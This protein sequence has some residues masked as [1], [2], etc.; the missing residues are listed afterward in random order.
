MEP[1]K[2]QALSGYRLVSDPVTLDSQLFRVSN[3]LLSLS[4]LRALLP[5]TNPLSKTPPW[6][7]SES[8]AMRWGMGRRWFP[9]NLRRR[10]VRLAKWCWWGVYERRFGN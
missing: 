6:R 3:F 4:S 1:E 8:W 10:G 7:G 5:L 2:I 9:V